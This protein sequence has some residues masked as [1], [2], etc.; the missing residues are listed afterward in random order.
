MTFDFLPL[1]GSG[2]AVAFSANNLAFALI[3]CLLGTLIG[4]L[5]GIGVLATIAM[6][7]PLTIGLP[8]TTSMIMLAGIYYGA[9]Y[10][11][12]TTAILVNLPGEATSVVTCLD[13]HKMAQQGKGGVALFLAATGSFAAGCF[14]TLIIA[15]FAPPLAEAAL[16]FNGPENFSLMLLALV[17]SALFSGAKLLHALSMLVLGVMLGLIG[18]DVETGTLRYTLGLSGLSDG[19]NFVAVVMGFFGLSEVVNN[20]ANPASNRTTTNAIGRFWPNRSEFRLAWP[21]CLRGTMLGSAL[22][23]LPGGGVVISPFASYMMEKRLAKDPTRFGQGAVEGVAGPEAANN[24]SAQTSFIPMLTLGIPANPVI[25]LLL[26]AMIIQGIQPGP[27]V[28]TKHPELF[29]GLVASMFIGNLMLLVINLP[30]ISLWVRLLIIP[31][32]MLFPAVLIFCCIGAYTL[33]NAAFDVVLLGVF[34]GVGIIL[35]ALDFPI[36]PLVLGLILG[37]LAEEHLRRAMVIARGDPMVFVE[38]PISSA[39]LSVTALMIVSYIFVAVR[40]GRRLPSNE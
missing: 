34:G 6:L 22:G 1:L 26:G 32:R 20:I 29:W 19:L 4:V 15:A 12:S 21:A 9:Q 3:G 23:V 16:H 24:A 11:G 25:A 10:G 30:L 31:Y 36:I 18:T 2:L 37:P 13:G 27:E 14:G 40:D 17:A 35:F 8:A 7:L 33:N 39:I 28:M 5:P 38:R